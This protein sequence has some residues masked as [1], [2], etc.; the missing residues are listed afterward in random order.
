MIQKIIPI[1]LVL[2]LVFGQNIFLQQCLTQICKLQPQ[3]SEIQQ[4]IRQN[5]QC[6]GFINQNLSDCQNLQCSVK[7]S[8]YL[9]Y[10]DQEC[11]LNCID[12]IE[13]QIQDE[14]SQFLAETQQEI[15]E[16]HEERQ[17]TV[18]K[19]WKLQNQNLRGVVVI[20]Q[21][22]VNQYNLNN[23]LKHKNTFPPINN[24]VII[25]PDNIQDSKEESNKSQDS[26]AQQQQQ[27]Q[28]QQIKINPK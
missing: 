26:S 5:Q 24:A 10:E 8:A 15:V 17:E 28:T 4:C 27:I 25:V 1:I 11:L 23:Q 18:Q 20:S 14:C 21:S 3:Q 12:K 19:M 7:C 6:D 22:Q 13:P 9:S 16:N 2:K